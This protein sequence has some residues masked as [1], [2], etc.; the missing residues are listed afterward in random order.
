LFVDQPVGTGL[1]YAD[2]DFANVYCKSMADV[3]NDFWVA[4]GNLYNNAN[5]CFK[6]LNFA[7]SQDLI[8]FGESYAGKYVPA[9]A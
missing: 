9:I 4:L 5:G 3:A 6:K 7:P 1:S 8:I 2:P